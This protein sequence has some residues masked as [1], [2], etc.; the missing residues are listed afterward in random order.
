MSKNG[1]TD[2]IDLIFNALDDGDL[3]ALRTLDKRLEAVAQEQMRH[4]E[5]RYGQTELHEAFYSLSSLHSTGPRTPRE[6]SI[7]QDDDTRP[8]IRVIFLDT[9][10]TYLH[11]VTVEVDGVVVFTR[12]QD[13]IRVFDEGDWIDQLVEA[14]ERECAAKE[15]EELRNSIQ[16][17]IDRLQ[18]I[19][20]T[21][22]KGG[23]HAQTLCRDIFGEPALKT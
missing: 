15:R 18:A 22:E 8:P 7:H 1:Q 10:T 20:L 14:A 9:S 17:S 23:L 21:S 19:Q 16:E 5:Q 2:D 12:Y 6:V 11:D 4:A 3:D 13:Q